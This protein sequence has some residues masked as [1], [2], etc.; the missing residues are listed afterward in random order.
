LIQTWIQT[1]QALLTKLDQWIQ[2]PTMLGW[3]NLI[4]TEGFTELMS[5]GPSVEIIAVWNDFCQ[6]ELTKSGVQATIVD[7]MVTRDGMI[8]LHFYPLTLDC[9]SVP[10][11]KLCQEKEALLTVCEE[12]LK[13]AKIR[14]L[15]HLHMP[16]HEKSLESLQFRID[17]VTKIIESYKNELKILPMI[18]SEFSLVHAIFKEWGFSC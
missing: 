3:R 1:T 10:F 5:I 9:I 16:N 7:N 6:N 13:Q 15:E 2:E 14:R 18:K 12:D 4:Y 11:D 8:M 17:E